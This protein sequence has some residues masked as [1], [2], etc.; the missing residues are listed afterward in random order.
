MNEGEEAEKE[1]RR[2]ILEQGARHCVRPPTAT[3][4]R[5]TLSVRAAGSQLVRSNTLRSLSFAAERSPSAKIGFKQ[6]YKLCSH[7]PLPGRPL[8]G[9]PAPPVAAWPR[10]THH[11]ALRQAT[12]RVGTPTL[13]T[14]RGADAI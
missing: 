6:N 8:A 10:V 9:R 14:P 13:C 1:R 4:E 11:A 7:A 12:R 3:V 5:R 2:G